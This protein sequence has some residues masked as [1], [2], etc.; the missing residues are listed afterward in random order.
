MK[1]KQVIRWYKQSERMPCK[2]YY[3]D[4]VYSDYVLL[5]NDYGVLIHMY[6]YDF[7]KNSW[8]THFHEKAVSGDIEN[9]QWAKIN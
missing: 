2:I 1:R 9:Y 8:M 5:R 4:M 3:D 6:Y 7:K